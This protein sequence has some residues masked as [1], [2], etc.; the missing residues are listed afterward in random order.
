MLGRGVIHAHCIFAVTGGPSLEATK[1]AFKSPIN[2]H[3]T[4]NMGSISLGIL[5]RDVKAFLIRRD[6]EEK[7]LS[8]NEG[9]KPTDEGP[10]DDTDPAA[11]DVTMETDCPNTT[12]EGNSEI[13]CPMDDVQPCDEELAETQ[14]PNYESD[15]SQEDEPMEIESP[16][17]PKQKWNATAVAH[18]FDYETDSQETVAPKVVK[19]RDVLKESYLN[20]SKAVI[21]TKMVENFVVENIGISN[22]HPIMDPMR[23]KPPFGQVNIFFFFC[24][25]IKSEIKKNLFFENGV[26]K[27]ELLFF[28]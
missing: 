14:G 7:G 24:I 18:R 17:K 5:V 4:T 3:P 16:P 26:P 21:G 25:C 11:A 20:Y 8:E 1:A 15:I 27:V 22:L 12:A 6:K 9:E 2:I 19:K 10:K 23:W 13:P 28:F